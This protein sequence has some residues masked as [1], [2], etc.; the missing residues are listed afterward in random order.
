MNPAAHLPSKLALADSMRF[1]R[2]KLG[3]RLKLVWMF[4]KVN[5]NFI[6]VFRFYGYGLYIQSYKYY[7]HL[8]EKVVR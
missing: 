1:V 4:E 8:S 5:N 6:S 7:K 2:K 3:T